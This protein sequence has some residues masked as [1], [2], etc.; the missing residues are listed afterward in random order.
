MTGEHKMY[1]KI[2]E[3]GA[4]VDELRRKLSKNMNKMICSN[5]FKKL[6]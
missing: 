1:K 3:V 6:K 4:E 5:T 2:E